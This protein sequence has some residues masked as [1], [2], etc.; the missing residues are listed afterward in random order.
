MLSIA[1]IFLVA[2][3][4]VGDGFLGLSTVIPTVI[5]VRDRLACGEERRAPLER[6]GPRRRDAPLPVQRSKVPISTPLASSLPMT[7]RRRSSAVHPAARP[8]GSR[9]A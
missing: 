5:A 3:T 6:A 9:S 4:L 8:L 7:A 2:G 1:L